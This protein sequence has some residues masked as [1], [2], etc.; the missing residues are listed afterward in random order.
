MTNKY[1]EQEQEAVYVQANQKSDA[2]K[3]VLEQNDDF[4]QIKI[5]WKICYNERLILVNELS[6]FEYMRKFP[7][8][9]L[10][11]GFELVNNNCF[12]NV[13]LSLASL[14][15]YFFHL[16]QFVLDADTLY[17]NKKSKLPELAT[18]IVEFGSLN[19][20]KKKAPV[21]LKTFMIEYDESAVGLDEESSEFRGNKATSIFFN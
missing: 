12:L 6:T 7:S 9:Q 14:Q 19:A 13:T 8:L 15:M 2:L 17:P 20:R 21:E 10:P 16:P 4:E 5:A 18:K 1:I 3:L 11:N